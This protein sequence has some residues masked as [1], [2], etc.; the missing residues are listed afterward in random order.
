VSL[1]LSFTDTLVRLDMRDDGIGFDPNAARKSGGMGLRNIEE[2]VARS[3]GSLVL[4][5][6]PGQGTRMRVELGSTARSSESA[7]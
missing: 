3:G 4:E 7:A 1:R 5:S 6:A 2:R